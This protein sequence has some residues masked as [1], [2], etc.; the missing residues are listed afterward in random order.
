MI[1]R[2]HSIGEGVLSPTEPVEEISADEF[3]ALLNR[4]IGELQAG[5][6]APAGD[7]DNGDAH[8][9]DLYGGG[10][11]TNC[12]YIIGERVSEYAV[13]REILKERCGHGWHFDGETLH[14]DDLTSWSVE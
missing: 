6:A 5:K 1:P 10:L 12:V 9:Q 13:P 14:L 3:W 7:A 8:V 11:T 4:R 2:H